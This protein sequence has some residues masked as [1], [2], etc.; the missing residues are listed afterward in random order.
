[1]S[2]AKSLCSGF[3]FHSRLPG[4]LHGPI[5]VNRGKVDAELAIELNDRFVMVDSQRE[6]VFLKD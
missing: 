3:L 2:L 1:L 5:G 6:R 4:L